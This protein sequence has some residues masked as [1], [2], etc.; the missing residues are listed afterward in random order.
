MIFWIAVAALA[1]GITF[2]VTRPLVSDRSAPQR[3]AA[4][5]DLEVYKDQLAEIDNDL[6]RGVISGEEAGA[7]R[8]EVSRRVLRGADARDAGVE[9]REVMPVSALQPLYIAASIALPVL[10]LGLYLMVGAPGQPG[11]PLSERLA[12]PVDSNKTGDLIAKVEAR[13]RDHPED[14][15]GWDVIGPVYLAQG[16]FEDAVTAYAR[17]IRLLGET[18][19]RLS[20]FAEARIRADNGI[21][22]EDARKALQGVLAAEPQRKQP[23]IWLGIAKEQ[24]GDLKGAADD[25]RALIA[26]APADAPWRQALEDRLAL[27][28]GSAKADT[29]APDVKT[30]NQDAAAPVE[31][32]PAGPS[33]ADIAAAEAMAPEQR[34]AMITKMV[35]GLAERLKTN[36]RD[37]VGWTKLIRAY[38]LMGRKDD[39]AKALSE[40]RTQ[41]TGDEPALKALNDLAEKLGLSG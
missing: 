15:K 10:S 38:Q 22:G 33:A 27:I 7:A 37:V 35:D 39:A 34:A 31:Q 30:D 25:Y 36:G 24:D 5:A 19:A 23:R 18:P 21:V 4:G 2:A 1:A 17:A 29:K 32:K 11:Q 40:A 6:A 26:D 28:D 8:A 14:G 3:D 9:A 12:A 20:G 41:L 13:L 16:N